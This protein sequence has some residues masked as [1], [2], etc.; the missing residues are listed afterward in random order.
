MPKWRHNQLSRSAEKKGLKGDRKNAY[1]YSVLNKYEKAHSG[2][3]KKARQSAY[4]K[5][6]NAA[7]GSKK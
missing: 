5:V 1:I 6:F 3:A 2:S 4:D 7:R